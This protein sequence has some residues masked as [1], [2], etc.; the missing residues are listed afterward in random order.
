MGDEEVKSATSQPSA[1]WMMIKEE[2]NLLGEQYS[3]GQRGLSDQEISKFISNDLLSRYKAM[4][5]N[6]NKD[7]SPHHY[8]VSHGADNMTKALHSVLRSGKLNTHGYQLNNLGRSSFGRSDG[9][10]GVYR[11]SATNKL[12]E[13]ELRGLIEHI[14]KEFQAKGVNIQ[15]EDI[16][17]GRVSQVAGS[18]EF[19][20][21]IYFRFR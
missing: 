15:K 10:L 18:N 5:G 13:P 12:S 19:I 11:F 9:S 1:D 16:K 8:Y 3:D 14:A 7:K 17:I 4:V 6:G 21:P 20:Y 2:L